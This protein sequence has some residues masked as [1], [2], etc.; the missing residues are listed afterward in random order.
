MTNSVP[1]ASPEKSLTHNAPR[2]RERF[3]ALREA[4]ERREH[5][6]PGDK[7]SP[8]KPD[9]LLR[10]Q[11]LERAILQLLTNKGI[12]ELSQ[13]R[14]L[15][16]G[17]GNGAWLRFLVQAGASPENLFGVDLLPHRIREARRKCPQ[18]STL[19]CGDA[20]QLPFENESFDLLLVMTVF[21]SIL[22]DHLRRLLAQEML[23]VLRQ[24][25]SILLY[26]FRVNNPRNPD[27]RRVTDQELRDLFSGCSVELHRI[28]LAPPVGR[29]V[30][31]SP[32][33]YWL[34]SDALVLCSHYLGWITP[35]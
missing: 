2:S 28:T 24:R 5:T 27:V 34:L 9:V 14:I 6:I 10:I 1:E 25:G 33:L 21:S 13:K 20:T 31:R 15:E 26:D 11:E 4:Y 17:C 22:D 18:A 7:Y 30:A 19:M 23:R 8:L 16:V 3:A 29:A 35:K 12:L 32:I